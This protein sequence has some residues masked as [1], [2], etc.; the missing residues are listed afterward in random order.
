M[1]NSN[2]LFMPDY[3]SIEGPPFNAD[4]IDV[5]LSKFFLLMITGSINGGARFIKINRI[6]VSNQNG[7][8]ERGLN[9][10]FAKKNDSF[11]R[12]EVHDHDHMI[13]T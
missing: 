6:P 4:V 11:R 2:G 8:I 3:Y 7:S 5:F 13:K 1:S 10:Y 12:L 9:F